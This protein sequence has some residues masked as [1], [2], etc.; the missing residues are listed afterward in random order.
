[1]LESV[2][3]AGLDHACLTAAVSMASHIVAEALEALPY[4]A[5]M[6]LQNTPP[7]MMM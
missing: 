4:F 2:Q 7:V 1:M 5:P 6:L 3:S